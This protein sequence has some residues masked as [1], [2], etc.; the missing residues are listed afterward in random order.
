MF[1]KRANLSIVQRLTLLYATAT[2]FVLIITS[3]A[4]Y[5]SLEHNLVTELRG[6]LKGQFQIIAGLVRKP[7]LDINILRQEVVTEP[8]LTESGINRNFSRI[9]RED[10]SVLIATPGMEDV[11][12]FSADTLP[13]PTI[14][15]NDA[16]ILSYAYFDDERF[17]VLTKAVPLPGQRVIY[18]QVSRSMENQ[19][20]LLR[21]YKRMIFIVL[22]VGALLSILLGIGLA[23]K[24]M[25]P[26]IKITRKLKHL[27][28]DLLH[29]RLDEAQW[30]EELV[31]MAS[32]FNQMCDRLEKSFKRLQ[33][34]SADLAHELRTP[35]N[36]LIGEIEITLQQT[37][38]L[39]EYQHV[40]ISNIEE[41]QRLS[42]MVS[43]LLFLAQT[44]N[45]H[46]QI[47][48]KRLRVDTIITQICDYYAALA[49]EKNIAITTQ[50]HA[51]IA[52]EET[53]FQRVISNILANAIKYTPE[54]GHISITIEQHRHNS[55]ITIQDNGVGV[56]TK[57]LPYL[58][59]RFYRTDKARNHSSGGL[60]LGL[61][62]VKSIMT[63]HGGEI[64]LSSEINQ[65]MTVT[66]TFPK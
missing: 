48:K 49:E 38:S 41:C 31:A 23:Q 58:F 43:G 9:I 66:L 59:D 50:G 11:T 36:N 37:R 30:P 52:I 64:N 7:P 21:K 10:H 5:E 47:E 14:A 20:R 6:Q 45:A 32:A 28:P 40:L 57:D 61:A 55:T 53:L 1:W 13:P 8:M 35:I 44:E 26:L 51:S 17:L 2:L 39:E 60:G 15:M 33:Q 63:L 18:I 3:I 12:P 34:F 65:G 46:A 4:L 29:Q 16:D 24:S 56:A 27:T 22:F 19:Q 25:R 42:K 62:I 54:G